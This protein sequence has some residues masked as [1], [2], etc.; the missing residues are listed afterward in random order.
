MRVADLVAVGAAIFVPLAMSFLPDWDG[1]L[2]RLMF[3]V[4]YL[5][6]GLELLNFEP[7]LERL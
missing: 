6:Y 4:A 5:W 2:Q 1:L 7:K 3:A